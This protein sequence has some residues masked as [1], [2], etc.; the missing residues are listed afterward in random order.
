MTILYTKICK[1]YEHLGL[2]NVMLNKFFQNS[3]KNFFLFN[4]INHIS[5][6]FHINFKCRHFYSLLF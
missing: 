4:F 5:M 6:N 3:V 2:Y 1:K